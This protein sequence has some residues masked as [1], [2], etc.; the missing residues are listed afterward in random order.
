MRNNFDFGGAAWP[1]VRHLTLFCGQIPRWHSNIPRS[2]LATKWV[3][4]SSKRLE[5]RPR[6]QLT[7]LISRIGH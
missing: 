1:P 2:K 3:L 4:G 7:Y 6:V 5:F